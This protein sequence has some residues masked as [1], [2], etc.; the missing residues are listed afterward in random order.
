MTGL[1]VFKGQKLDELK[2]ILATEK[3]TFKSIARYYEVHHSTVINHARHF[4]Y[5][6]GHAIYMAKSCLDCKKQIGNKSERC[7][8]CASKR[9]ALLGK[10]LHPTRWDFIDENGEKINMGK[11]Y[12]GYLA[13]EKKKHKKET[14]EQIIARKRQ[15]L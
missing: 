15:L 12:S 8:K 6:F 2:V 10:N 7:V 1:H 13:D 9:S 11:P 4:G 14:L 5:Q 3:Y